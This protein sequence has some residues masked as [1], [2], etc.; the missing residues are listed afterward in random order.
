MNFMKKNLLLT[1]FVFLII[2]INSLAGHAQT[3][4]GKIIDE[5][6]AP[7]EFVNVVL[8]SMPD[9]AFVSGAISNHEGIFTLEKK[10][11]QGVLRVSSVGYHTVYQP[12]HG[13]NDVGIIRLKNDSQML[14]E[15]EVK[16]NLPVTRLQGD[17]LVTQVEGSLLS[18]AGSGNDVLGKIPGIL[19]N[20]DGYEVFGKGT[21][22][23]YIN[24]RK[25]RNNDELEQLNSEDI[26]SVE[27][28]TNPGARYDAT[29]SAVI[30]IQTIRRKGD[31]FGFNARTTYY[32]SEYNADFVEQ[33]SV[34][35]RH[36]GL[37]VFG[38]LYMSQMEYMQDSELL[39]W[40][41]ADTLWE[42]Q[43]PMVAVGKT[44][45]M[46]GEV[47]FNYQ[48]NEKHSL[49]LTY[50]LYAKPNGETRMDS[51]NKILA[52]G[53]FGGNLKSH[54]VT[55]ESGKPTHKLNTYY[56][57]TVGDW[58]IDL[59]ADYYGS[60]ST[61]TSI[62]REISQELDNREVNTH[63]YVRNRL[64]AGKLIVSRPLWGG[65]LS[66]GGEFSNIRRND[67][68]RNAES[69]IPT[70]LSLVKEKNW[71]G[72]V[73]YR[74]NFPVGTLG[75]GLRYE[76][77]DFDYYEDNVFREGQS[78][79]YGRWFP[80]AS[81]STKIGPVQTMLSYAVKTQRPSYRELSNNLT[82]LDRFSMQQGN[83]LLEPAYTHDVTW[84]STWRFLQ[85]SVNYQQ[86]KKEIINWGE[87]VENS[88]ATRLTYVN[89]DNIPRL[90]VFLAAS[91]T[92]GI[93]HPTLSVGLQKQWMDF[94]GLSFNT[95]MYLM[96]L[97]N[98]FELPGDIL[99]SVDGNV[100]WKGNH[101]NLYSTRIYQHVDVSLR[102]SFLK[103]ALTVE[104]RGTD[105]FEG[106]RDCW[107]MFYG[108]DF[109]WNQKN[110]FDSREFVFT[111]RYKFN[112]A[113]S[114]YKG[115]GAGQNQMN[116]L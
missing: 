85:L 8:L 6:E 80:T 55:L 43:N 18:K 61:G 50:S 30:R 58:N 78:R 5:Q 94:D 7:L 103:D 79:E 26:K 54:Q 102:K 73:E 65:N 15:V 45:S 76:F 32:Q 28:V 37:D 108:K 52:D 17:A 116:R 34:N 11:L 1:A 41:K 100:R 33:A 23:I 49:G 51:E 57:G 44:K 53:M 3:L 97:N 109:V 112:S 110:H 75:V 64:W 90:K 31:G 48:L 36:N 111:L 59:N 99:L 96:Q 87:A 25:M 62:T 56:N 113:K 104:L 86:T 46:Q 93:W 101:Q 19:K 39:H 13:K 92:I 20:K 82:Y 91:P 98:S 42:F 89:Y 66:V 35:Y 81:F 47:G 63:S 40:V 105:L 16:G 29:V 10:V 77:V 67:E 38:S 95:P 114:K 9:S 83:P 24:G 21:P 69:Y 2:H 27:V 115:T 84:A 60:T 70:T 12:V 72:F 88:N 107:R 74:K 14:G 106:K 4:T 22:L 71:S 68:Y